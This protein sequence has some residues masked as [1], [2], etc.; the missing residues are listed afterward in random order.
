MYALGNCEDISLKSQLSWNDIFVAVAPYLS[1][2]QSEDF[3]QGKIE[4]GVHRMLAGCL[5]KLGD[6]LD[7]QTLLVVQE[8]ERLVARERDGLFLDGGSR[9]R[10]RRRRLVKH[11]R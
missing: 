9:G 4:H 6:G 1:Q 2:P 3:I 11:P 7:G 10:R 8:H 5:G